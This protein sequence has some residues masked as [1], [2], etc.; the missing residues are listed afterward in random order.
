MKV[1]GIK[2]LKK[3]LDIR[4]TNSQNMSDNSKTVS[5]MAMEK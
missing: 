4:L 5:E 3:D 1:N 2:A